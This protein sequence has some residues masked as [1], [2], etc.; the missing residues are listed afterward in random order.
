MDRLVQI[1][2]P[3]PPKYSVERLEILHS[4]LLRQIDRRTITDSLSPKVLISKR[5][6]MIQLK[7]DPNRAE[8]LQDELAEAFYA[9]SAFR[10]KAVQQGETALARESHEESIATPS[11]IALARSIESSV[12]ENIR[13]IGEILVNGSKCKNME[14][15]IR[16]DEIFEYFGENSMLSLFTQMVECSP[17]RKTNDEENPVLWTPRVKAQ[18]LH[19]VSLMVSSTR[20]RSALLYILSNNEVNR[21]IM[22]MQPLSQWTDPALDSMLPA[23]CDLL[24]NLSLQLGGRPELSPFFVTEKNE[25][26]FPLFTAALDTLR[27]SYAQSCSYVHST[28]LNALVILLQIETP[29][30][31]NCVQNA[32][33]EQTLLTDHLCDLLQ[34]RYRRICNLA[35]GPVLDPIRSH[36][37]VAQ[38][39]GLDDQVIVLND[40]LWSGIKNLNLLLC[41]KI[42]R[43]LQAVFRDVVASRQHSFGS[44]VGILDTD[45]IP[46]REARTQTAIIMLSRLF[47]KVEFPPLIRLLFV[48]LFHPQSN[49]SDECHNDES[50]ASR[51]DEIVKNQNQNAPVNNLRLEL[52]NSLSGSCGEWRFIA[53]AM[54]FEAVFDCDI[55]DEEILRI[56]QLIPYEGNPFSDVSEALLASFDSTKFKPSEM[57]VTAYEICTGI[58]LKLV[59]KTKE[60]GASREIQLWADHVIQVLEEARNSFYHRLFEHHEDL[61]VA[62]IFVD[63]L[64]SAVNEKYKV[65][66]RKTGRRGYFLERSESKAYVTKASALVRK[67]PSVNPSTVESTRFYARMSLHFR[68]ICRVLR[69]QN[70][71][72]KGHFH[73][74]DDAAELCNVFLTLRPEPALGVTVD[75]RGRMA[76]MFH[77][78]FSDSSIAEKFTLILDPA[79]MM[80]VSTSSERPNRG[81]LSCCIPLLH[82]VAAAGD[83]DWLHIA[84]SHDDVKFLIKN[85]NMAIRFDNP[86][87]CLIVEQYL[88]R[89]RRVLR[90][91]L[92]FRVKELFSDKD[93]EAAID[94]VKEAKTY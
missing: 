55:L 19:T 35:S 80:V 49:L 39:G 70:T 4:E 47:T 81:T 3:R 34:R 92:L 32:E 2:N 59:V 26:A 12:V 94:E 23:Y 9:M 1:L 87:T 17:Y 48:A 42:L 57:S 85:G 6:S 44:L 88:N 13:S 60:Y 91:E 46:E 73:A 8:H 74:L 56:G 45:V 11:T 54:L 21:L 83:A 71:R 66:D 78:V 27:S 69:A 76:F 52:I 18:V 89:S 22:S 25:T 20:E 36:A 7:N 24:K 43:F 31:H 67:E 79:D 63:I 28:C 64:E 75:T 16:A 29:L 15:E 38:W 86:S 93:S 5:L 30:V 53:T 50:L 10:Y 14:H 58:L 77:S 41:E 51:L 62:N 90:Q 37:I 68:A 72:S 33:A 61:S 40:V 65:I 84:V 82:V